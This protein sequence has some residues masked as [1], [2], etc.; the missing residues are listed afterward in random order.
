MNGNIIEWADNVRHLGSFVYVT[1][2]DQRLL[3]ADSLHCYIKMA[4][5]WTVQYTTHSKQCRVLHR[6]EK[7]IIYYRCIVIC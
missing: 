4:A 2:Y 1:L 5:A 7:N 6:S 3:D